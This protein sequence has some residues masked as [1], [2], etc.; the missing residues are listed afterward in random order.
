[1]VENAGHGFLPVDEKPID[2]SLKEIKART[3]RFFKEKLK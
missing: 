2:P 1:M 3:L